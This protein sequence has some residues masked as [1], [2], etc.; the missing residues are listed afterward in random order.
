[1]YEAHFGLAEAPFGVNPDPRFLFLSEVHKEALAHLIY[2]V[3]QRKGFI[4]ITGDVGTGKTTLLN[5]LLGGLNE[6]IRCVFITNPKLA[7][8]DFLRTIAYQLKLEVAKNF[9]KADFL[10][11]MEALLAESLRRRENVLLVVDEAQNLSADLLEE[12][13]LLSNLETAAEKMLQIILVGQQELNGKLLSDNLRQLRQRV[14]IKYHLE[15]LGEGET[16]AY[17]NHRLKVAGNGGRD[18]FSHKA[19]RE[20][21]LASGGFPRLINNI[22]DNAMLAAYSRDRS[23][24]DGGLVQETVRDLEASYPRQP[25]PLPD[26][27]PPEAPEPPSPAPRPR[28]RWRIYGAATALLL[29]LL[30]AVMALLHNIWGSYEPLLDLLH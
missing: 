27:A 10:I 19:M 16:A 1:M 6:R 25:R 14:S 28:R 24:V 12:I 11:E 18:I 15:P 26:L 9:N 29:A 7:T 22:C 17:I 3:R 5:K 2:G 8:D 20:V 23:R 13:R 30:L 4:V 21:Y